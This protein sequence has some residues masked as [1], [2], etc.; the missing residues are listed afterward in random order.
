MSRTFVKSMV[1][2]GAAAGLVLSTVGGAFPAGKPPIAQDPR[3]PLRPVLFYN[4]TV[5]VAQGLTPR[6][7]LHRAR[8]FVPYRVT[9][10]HYLPK[11]F[12]LVIVRVYPYIPG[13]M[14]PQDT[15]T[16]MKLSAARKPRGKQARPIAV[17][18]F[19]LDHQFGQP[20]TYS[21]G[22]AYFT[23]RVV[24][25]GHRR[26]SVAEQK[27]KDLRTH[28]SVDTLYVYW[29]DQKSKAATEV[30]ADLVSSKLSRAQ[31]FKIA[32]SIP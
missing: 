16:F 28:K 5:L 23:V 27:Y 12:R 13:T 18:S 31:V 11:G 20:Y 6:A 26:V 22:Q 2:A 30:T 9:T 1:A 19:E 4:Q 29:Y 24:K 32:A 8:R 15:Q 14:E 10:V 17:P 21:S 7:A 25:L 3:K